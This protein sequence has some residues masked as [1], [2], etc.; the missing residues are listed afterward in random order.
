[1]PDTTIEMDAHPDPADAEILQSLMSEAVPSNR[2]SAC[3]RRSPAGEDL[4]A[5]KSRFV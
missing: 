5:M 4:V 1:M 3:A 2:R